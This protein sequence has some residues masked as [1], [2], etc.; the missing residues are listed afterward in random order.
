MTE[1]ESD[2]LS[3]FASVETSEDEEDERIGGNT[4]TPNYR[5]SESDDIGFNN[6]R[7]YQP[8]KSKEEIKNEREEK[9]KQRET[10]RQVNKNFS[11]YGT[12]IELMWDEV[13]TSPAGDERI[14]EQYSNWIEI[15]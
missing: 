6:Q 9:R 13:H 8:E 2:A 7:Y 12:E 15:L 4:F 3:L 5:M 1:A 10:K 14:A 11:E